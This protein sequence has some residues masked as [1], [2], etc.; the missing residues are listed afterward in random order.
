MDR[1]LGHGR[2]AGLAALVITACLTGCH[3]GPASAL[4]PASASGSDGPAGAP[5]A[6]GTPT[7]ATFPAGTPAPS[8]CSHLVE[9]APRVEPGQT[10][11]EGTHG[12]WVV[13]YREAS[14][15][16]TSRV[17]GWW[18]A[19]EQAR[20]SVWK[21][22]VC[23]DRAD[24]RLVRMTTSLVTQA[25]WAGRGPAQSLQITPSWL[26]RTW[27]GATEA[28]VAEVRTSIPEVTRPG[29]VAQLR[30]HV[31]FASSKE[32]WNLEPGRPDVGY[33]ATVAAGCNPGD[34]VDPDGR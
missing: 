30:C 17:T 5:P 2:A 15:P 9:S 14:R 11:G 12:T 23:S 26:A 7:P 21:G 27:P 28:V 6:P 1:R 18:I 31:A 16:G 22:R 24:T 33:P 13:T 20:L 10:L 8:G 4:A 19:P 34:V 32:R 3:G 25:R 29:M